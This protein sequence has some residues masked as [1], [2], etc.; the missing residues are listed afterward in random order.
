MYFIRPYRGNSTQLIHDGAG[1]WEHPGGDTSDLELGGIS[2]TGGIESPHITNRCSQW[3]ACLSVCKST[4]TFSVTSE[5]VKMSV[6]YLGD[7]SSGADFRFVE[8][9]WQFTD[10][11]GTVYRHMQKGFRA[12]IPRQLRSSTATWLRRDGI[13]LVKIAEVKLLEGHVQ[14]LESLHHA[15]CLGLDRSDD[16]TKRFGFFMVPKES[17]DRAASREE[18]V[19]LH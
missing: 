15:L 18:T 17:W 1:R 7:I 9:Q 8:S 3:L 10:N 11:V 2:I 13:E 5:V 14:R 12:Y 6:E 4:S 19:I 16:V